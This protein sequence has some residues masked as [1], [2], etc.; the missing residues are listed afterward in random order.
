ME[1]PAGEVVLLACQAL[2]R[3]TAFKSMERTLLL[4]AA[5][6]I[7]APFDREK[8]RRVR[9][10]RVAEARAQGASRFQQ[11]WCGAQAPFAL[12]DSYPGMTIETV[13]TELPAARLLG[14]DDIDEIDFLPGAAPARSRQHSPSV[15]PHKLVLMMPKETISLQ[16]DGHTD[17]RE[18]RRLLRDIVHGKIVGTD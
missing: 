13:Q 8:L 9:D 1:T 10:A 7:V 6:I 4:T 3:Q 18:L 5:H 12:I 14:D 15:P 16:V 17:P 11:M 2:E